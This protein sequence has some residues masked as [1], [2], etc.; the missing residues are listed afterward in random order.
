MCTYMYTMLTALQ[1]L[2]WH[3]LHKWDLRAFFNINANVLKAWLEFI[4]NCYINTEYHNSKSAVSCP[5]AGF[6]C[7]NHLLMP[8]TYGVCMHAF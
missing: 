3:A 4:E 2:G 6:S 5:R 7:S 1:V 8:T